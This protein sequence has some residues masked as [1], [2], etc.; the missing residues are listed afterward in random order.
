MAIPDTLATRLIHTA[1]KHDLGGSFLMLGRQTFSGSRRGPSAKAL[2]QA[3][4]EHFDGMSEDDLRNTEDRFS[5]TFFFKLGFESVDSLDFSPFEGAS[6]IHDLTQPVGTDLASRF[7]VIY[8]GGTCEHVF[9][10]MS[11]FRNIDMMLRP[12]GV[13]IGHSPCNNSINHAFYQFGP[14]IVYGFWEKAMGYEV[15]ELLLQPLRPASMH[16]VARTSNPNKTGVRPRIIGKLPDN[17]PII[18]HYA[19]RKPLLR[20]DVRTAQQ[21]DYLKRW[22]R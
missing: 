9:D 5:E 7:D 13:L 6:I 12:G 1:K 4:D 17:S 15:L 10:V 22:A 19:V 8:D 18:M 11:A 21:T 20:G 2:A 16:K 14:E 3:I